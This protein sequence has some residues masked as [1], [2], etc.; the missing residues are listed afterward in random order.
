MTAD[1]DLDG[2]VTWDELR[3]L[4]A[5]NFADFDKDHL[6]KITKSEVETMCKGH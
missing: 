2:S 5:Q 3:A 1:T 6:G 4:V